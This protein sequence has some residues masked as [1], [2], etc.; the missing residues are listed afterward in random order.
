MRIDWTPLHREW[1]LWR[2]AGLTLPVWWRDDDATEPS[3]AL[4]Q[5]LK[6][7]EQAAMPVHLAVIPSLALPSLADT[8]ADNALAIPVTHGWAHLNHAPPG[9]KKAEFGAHRPLEVTVREAQLG[10]DQM[11]SL[12]GASFTPLFVPPWNRID[13]AL[14]ALLGAI[15][16][17]ALSTYLPRTSAFAAPDVAQINT[18]IDPIFWRGH[19]GLVD[20][21]LL[22]SQLVT[23]LR[24]RREGRADNAEPLGY[25][26]HH[27]VHDGD[28]WEF[29]RQYWNELMNGP[30]TVWQLD[31]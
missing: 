20:P 29:T 2:S 6:I 27:L 31:N 21:D 30:V 24:D 17:R 22:I 5:L 12:F 9:K 26:T 18:H 15:G 8:L 13:L 28:I 3:T 25:L 10:F 16:Y 11:K 19:R 4:D 14:A 23:L 1:R 7:S